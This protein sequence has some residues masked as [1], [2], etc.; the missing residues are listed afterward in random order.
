VSD[1]SLPPVDLTFPPTVYE[2]MARV[3]RGGLYASLLLLLAA[4]AVYLIEHPS[5][6]SS[7]A[8][9]SNPILQFLSAGG[10]AG[11]LASGSPAAYLTL[12]LIVLVATPILRV[13]S[14]LYYFRR[15]GER[16]MSALTVTVLVLLLLG[17]L[18]I[19]PLVR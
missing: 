17:L 15:G 11:G 5:L 2:R 4:L 16:T 10:L 19:G 12:G 18:V 13:A 3:L 1:T 14:G 9:G 8:I 6:T 7:Q